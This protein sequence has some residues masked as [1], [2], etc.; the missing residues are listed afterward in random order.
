MHSKTKPYPCEMTGCDKAFACL[1]E[2]KRHLAFHMNEPGG[3]AYA[4]CVKKTLRPTSAPVVSE[5]GKAVAFSV[6][7]VAGAASAAVAVPKPPLRT[8]SMQL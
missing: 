5:E 8:I 3:I 1:S 4:E 6:I 2:L 7:D